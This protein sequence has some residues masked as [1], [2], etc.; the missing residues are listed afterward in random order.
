[1]VLGWAKTF[2]SEPIETVTVGLRRQ[3]GCTFGFAVVAD[4]ALADV[5]PDSFDALAVPGGVES[6]G[7]YGDAYSDAVLNVLR[8]LDSRTRPIAA[9][10]VAALPLAKAGVL[11]GR[12]A[13]TYHLLGGK[14]REQL[15]A[16]G[17]EVVDAPLV[18]DRNV[19]TSTGPATATDVAFW[20]LEE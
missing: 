19:L 17:A 16:M 5:D 9:V 20:L 15:A 12:R 6:A 2:G 4:A 3:L 11:A 1:D 8:R 10:C 14:R 13:T 18:R 7:F